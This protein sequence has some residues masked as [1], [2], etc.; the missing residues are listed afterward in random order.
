[1]LETL[2]DGSAQPNYQDIAIPRGVIA[3]NPTGDKSL[4]STSCTMSSRMSTTTA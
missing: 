3:T 4:P 1:M 2:V